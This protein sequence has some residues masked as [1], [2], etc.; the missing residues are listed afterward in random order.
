MNKVH[1][2]FDVVQNII[3]GKW[4]NIILY[5][6]GYGNKRTKDLLKIC[7]GVSHKVLNEQLKQL[8]A[9]GLIKRA[10]YADEVPIRVEYSL[11]EYGRS[12]LSLL[13]EMC[14]TGDE[15]LKKQGIT[16]YNNKVCEYYNEH[17]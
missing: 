7:E 17:T 11:T 1:T 6:L 8:Q 12:F 5:Q 16:T 14:D 9:G 10:V 3:S 4:K 13:K 2:G 15:H